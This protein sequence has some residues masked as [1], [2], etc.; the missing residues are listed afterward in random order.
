[1]PGT[2]ATDRVSLRG[3]GFVV[4]GIALSTSLFSVI[5]TVALFRDSAIP[6]LFEVASSIPV[7][8]NSY[9]ALSYVLGFLVSYAFFYRGGFARVRAQFRDDG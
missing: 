6:V 1:M 5:S 8:V 9:L 4:A 3:V 7:G 2:I